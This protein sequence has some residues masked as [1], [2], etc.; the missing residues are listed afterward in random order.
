MAGM[1]SK[2]RCSRTVEALSGGLLGGVG[3]CGY[4]PLSGE[5]GAAAGASSDYLVYHVQFLVTSVAAR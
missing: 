5:P 3:R 1:A 4:T 2:S